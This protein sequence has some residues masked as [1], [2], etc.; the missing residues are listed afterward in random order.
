MR[1]RTTLITQ[2]CLILKKVGDVFG[3]LPNISA[4]VLAI[5]INVLEL[6]EGFDDVYVVAEVDDDVFGTGV[7]KIVEQGQRLEYVPPVLALIVETLV[8][9]SIIS[10]NS[11]LAVRAQS[12]AEARG[13]R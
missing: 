12:K 9:I 5:L 11:F 13:Q 7:K 6:L 10:M 3:L 8:R 2:T 4:L 1:T